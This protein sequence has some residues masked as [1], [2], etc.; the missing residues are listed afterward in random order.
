MFSLT[1]AEISHFLLAMGCLLATAHLLGFLAERIF[2]PRVIGEVAAGLVLGP[3]LLGHFFPDA[4]QWLFLGFPTEDKLFGL[5]Y[6]FGLLMLMFTS[7]LKFQTQ[8]NKEDIKLTSGLVI[9]ATIPAFIVGWFAADLFNIAPFIGSANN[10]LA[11]KIVIAIS[12]AITSI[13]VISKIFNDLGIMHTRFAKIVVACAGIHDIFLWVALGF[14]TTLASQSGVFTVSTAMSSLGTSIAFI[15]G[16]FLL[17][18]FLFKRLT[19]T[20]QNLLFRSSNL[21][22]F[23][24]IMFILASIAG[25]LHVETIFGAL[26]AGIVAKVALPK[27]LSERV[28]QGVSNISFSWFIP[29]Y[30]A[31]VGLQLDLV[32][33]FSLLFFIGYLLF[34]TLT[35]TLAVYITSRIMK[36]DRF[37]SFNL[38]V[39][40]NDRGGPGIVLSSVAYTAGIINQ[41]F[42][43]ILVMLAL[44]TSW[45]PGTWLRVVVN[46]GW[47]LMPGDENLVLKYT[48][49]DDKK[50]V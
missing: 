9:G 26:L 45:I 29:I 37:T 41:E 48:N 34:A 13:P 24:F 2:I 11:M 23:L 4:F 44:V 22:Y 30:F 14:A 8:F 49:E 17:G 38:G 36:Q 10:P 40:I 5:L 27:T 6:Q 7:G 12:I 3:T 28:E 35:Q 16:T 42:F 1:S 39:A 19:I 47:R 32:R 50:W 31:T 15:V 46:K 21:G 43:A 25:N 20:K 18:Y 33:H